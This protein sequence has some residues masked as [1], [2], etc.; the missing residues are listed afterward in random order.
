[1]GSRHACGE[2]RWEFHAGKQLPLAQKV[3]VHK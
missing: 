2:A 3:L 1:M